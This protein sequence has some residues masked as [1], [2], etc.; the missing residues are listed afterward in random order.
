MI[1]MARVRAALATLDAAVARWPRLCEALTQRRLSMTLD[2][3]T[4]EDDGG[5]DGREEEDR[6]HGP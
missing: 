2:D 5:S 1:D 6:R 4:Q 3:A